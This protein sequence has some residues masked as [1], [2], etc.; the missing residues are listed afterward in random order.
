MGQTAYFL[1]A[2]GSQRFQGFVAAIAAFDLAV[3]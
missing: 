2:V 1:W 3:V